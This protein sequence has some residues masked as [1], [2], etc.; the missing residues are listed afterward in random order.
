MTGSPNRAALMMAREKLLSPANAIAGYC[1]VL[2]DEARESG[3]QEV[4]DDLARMADRSRL[5][6]QTVQALLN[7]TIAAETSERA[8]QTQAKLRHDLRGPLNVVITYAELVGDALPLPTDIL[9]V[10]DLDRV[11]ALARQMADSIDWVL[12][13][14]FGERADAPPDPAAKWSL[15]P[16]LGAALDAA[17]PPVSHPGLAG[18]AVLVVDD[19][20]I[21]GLLTSRILQV[22]GCTVSR[23]LDVDAATQAL[24]ET[25]FDAFVIDLLMPGESGLSFLRSV[26][27]NRAMARCVAIVVSGLDTPA[28]VEGCLSLGADDF[29]IKPVIPVLLRHRLSHALALKSNY[30]QGKRERQT[31]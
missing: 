7:G 29:L 21:G 22:E 17:G 26:R 4:V 9:T 1:S 19:D 8:A 11:T 12:G 24:A 3:A 6:V 18:K 23:A 10:H 13:F 28:I 25:D 15:P 16:D 5:L 2:Y 31:A 14:V 30:G 20:E 27:G